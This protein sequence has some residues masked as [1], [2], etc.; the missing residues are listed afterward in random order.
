MAVPPLHLDRQMGFERLVA[1]PQPVADDVNG[2]H[3]IVAE[4]E[5]L[6]RRAGGVAEA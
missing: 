1:G 6:C 4:L 3:E 5:V 2:Q